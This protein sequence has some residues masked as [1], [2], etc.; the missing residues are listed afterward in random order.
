[1]TSILFMIIIV[2]FLAKATIIIRGDTVKKVNKTTRQNQLVRAGALITGSLFFVL[3]IF[4][5]LYFDFFPDDPYLPLVLDK[6]T[7]VGAYFGICLFG[8]VSIL[9]FIRFSVIYNI[10][11]KMSEKIGMMLLTLLLLA[12]AP[13]VF[14]GILFASRIISDERYME[15]ARYIASAGAFF[16][17]IFIIWEYVVLSNAIVRLSRTKRKAQ[18][19]DSAIKPT[20]VLL[21]AI[22]G[23]IFLFFVFLFLFQAVKYR[24]QEYLIF[25]NIAGFLIGVC[26]LSVLELQFNLEIIVLDV[27]EHSNKSRKGPPIAI[28]PKEIELKSADDATKPVSSI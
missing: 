13:L 6:F 2:A 19:G 14:E 24:S 9:I 5:S 10:S 8:L 26:A 28:A 11:K 18:Q 12:A 22:I 3:A 27:L 21:C 4:S 20:H 23:C 16:F 25:R 1:M 15:Y 7:I 17:F